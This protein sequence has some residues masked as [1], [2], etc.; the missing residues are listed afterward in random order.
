MR[1]G[2]TQE[3]LGVGSHIIFNILFT[4]CTLT[5]KYLY[6]LVI[7]HQGRC[8]T[9]RCSSQYNIY[10]LFLKCYFLSLELLSCLACSLFYPS[11]HFCWVSRGL[12]INFFK[13]CVFF[14]YTYQCGVLFKYH[15]LIKWRVPELAFALKILELLEWVPAVAFQ[16]VQQSMFASQLTVI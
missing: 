5:T 9:S 13:F 14:C 3:A 8:S 2:H 7:S 1:M 4:G 12:L 16:L 10:F 6:I 11:L 15:Q